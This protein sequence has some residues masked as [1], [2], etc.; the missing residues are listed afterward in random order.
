MPFA[1][2]GW[3]CSV[4]PKEP[5]TPLRLPVTQ[6]AGIFHVGKF[7]P[8]HSENGQA[9]QAAVGGTAT[10]HGWH[11]PRH[12]PGPRKPPLPAPAVERGGRGDETRRQ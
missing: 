5:S 2:A 10:P 9:T 3:S 1:G 8:E 4:G 11:H 7:F 12:L 6:K